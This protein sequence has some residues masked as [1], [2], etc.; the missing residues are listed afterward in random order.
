MYLTS[1]VLPISRVVI[2]ANINWTRA[3]NKMHDL[4]GPSVGHFEGIAFPVAKHLGAYLEWF[5]DIP[6]FT[7]HTLTML[8][9]EDNVELVCCSCPDSL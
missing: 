9:D 3:T 1:M 6:P 4:S 2:L 8:P 5:A 7:E